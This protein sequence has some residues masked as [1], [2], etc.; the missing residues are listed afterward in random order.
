MDICKAYFNGVPRRDI[1]MSLPKELGLPPNRRKQIRCV[2]E[3]RDAGM[4]WEDCYRNALEDMGFKSSVASPCCFHHPTKGLHVVVHGDD[5][6]C[7][8]L[9][10]D[11]DYY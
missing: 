5:F 6:T 10:A 9:D 8:G 3:T 11:I 7:L 2:Y 4:I 1:F